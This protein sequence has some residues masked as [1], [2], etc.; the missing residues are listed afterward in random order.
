MANG[1]L[2]HNSASTDGTPEL[3]RKWAEEHPDLGLKLITEDERGG[4]WICCTRC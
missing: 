2:C 3:V 4:K 1:I